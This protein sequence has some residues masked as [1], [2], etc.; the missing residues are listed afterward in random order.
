V[1]EISESTR[2]AG[3]KLV[4]LKSFADKRGRFL[5]T[6]RKEW[7]PERTWDHV[8]G[9][10]SD[11]KAGVLR[12]LHYHFRQIDY[13]YLVSGSIRIGLYDLRRSSPTR[14]VGKTVEIT[15]T[16]PFGVFVPVGVAHGFL[17]LE[18]STLTYLVDD[19]YD[20]SDEFGVAWDDPDIGL[21][22]GTTSPLLSPRDVKNPRLRDIPEDRLPE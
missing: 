10:R 4:R 5:E 13:W 6:F 9:N 1:A 12:G 2:I 14:G 8:Q 18:D 7:F 3:V 11:S 16:E 15:E 22:W 21:D 19:Y 20:D 17:A